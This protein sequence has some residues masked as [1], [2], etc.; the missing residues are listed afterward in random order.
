MRLSDDGTLTPAAK[1]ALCGAYNKARRKALSLIR[2]HVPLD[3]KV[4]FLVVHCGLPAMVRFAEDYLRA[5]YKN[6]TFMSTMILGSGIACHSGP[7]AFGIVYYY[8]QL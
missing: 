4:M 5:T 6:I 8:D 3:A 7:E 2:Q 1:V